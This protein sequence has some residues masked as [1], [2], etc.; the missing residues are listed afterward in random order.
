MSP[1]KKVKRSSEAKGKA[2]K[3]GNRTKI[4]FHNTITYDRFLIFDVGVKIDDEREYQPI[5]EVHYQDIKDILTENLN[6]VKLTSR[7]RDEMHKGAIAGR[8][9]QFHILCQID[10][11][12]PPVKMRI[13]RSK[14]RQVISTTVRSGASYGPV[15]GRLCEVIYPSQITGIRHVN[16]PG[17]H[18]KI[19]FVPSRLPLPATLIKS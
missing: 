9:I 4:S 18:M 14:I 10:N 3:K 15:F 5:I 17:Q 13:L 2:Q 11:H 8:E 16:T 7:R 12:F 6:L 1:S 19:C